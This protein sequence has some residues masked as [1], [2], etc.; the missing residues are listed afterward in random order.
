MHKRLCIFYDI[1]WQFLFEMVS[2]LARI[3]SCLTTSWM[4]TVLI[5]PIY[6]MLSFN[7]FQCSVH[8]VQSWNS[9]ILSVFNQKNEALLEI[10]QCSLEPWTNNLPLNLY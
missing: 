8:V 6:P 10:F 1:L 7:T 3:R 9:I 4:I 2:Y 5:F